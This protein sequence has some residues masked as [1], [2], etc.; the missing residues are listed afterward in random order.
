MSHYITL[1]MLEGAVA[2]M[3]VA[4][5]KYGVK[6]DNVL[7]LPS[8]ET[9]VPGEF[10]TALITR[11]PKGDAMIMI[12]VGMLE[13]NYDGHFWAA[14]PDACLRPVGDDGSHGPAVIATAAT[15]NLPL[16]M[17]AAA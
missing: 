15:I 2:Q 9:S 14:N 8:R 1:D 16:T 4:E 5:E 17:D 10:E 6:I 12:A 11:V 13:K 3:R 7:V